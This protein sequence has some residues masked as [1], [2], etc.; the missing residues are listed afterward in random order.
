MHVANQI[1]IVLHPHKRPSESQQT[2]IFGKPEMKV[3]KV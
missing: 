2:Q 1:N 3:S